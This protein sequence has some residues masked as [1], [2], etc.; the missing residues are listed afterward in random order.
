VTA[1]AADREDPGRA[2]ARPDENVVCLR[3]AVNE[4]PRLQRAFLA[5]DDH[6]ALAEEDEEVLLL[7][8]AVVHASRLARRQD[9]DVDA[10]LLETGVAV[11]LE[12]RTRAECV[13]LEPARLLRVDDEPALPFRDKTS[14][15]LLERC[16]WNHPQP[17]ICW[18]ACRRKRTP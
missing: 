3:W 10:D 6:Q 12:G 18:A 5:F 16:L 14:L 13:V 17:P 11:A 8:L 9:T 4:V 7:V 1:A 2:V 15:A